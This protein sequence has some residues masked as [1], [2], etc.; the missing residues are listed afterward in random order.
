MG[1]VPEVNQ[2]K[3]GYRAVVRWIPGRHRASTVKGGV[4]I[5]ERQKIDLR[6]S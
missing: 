4:C 2:S 3:Q 1:Q 5:K 6:L